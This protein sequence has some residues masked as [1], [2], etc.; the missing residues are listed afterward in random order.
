MKLIMENWRNYMQESSVIILDES[1]MQPNFLK[2]EQL[3]EGLLE[4]E[5]DPQA[6]GVD[7]LA[8][9]PVEKIQ[10]EYQKML[11]GET[12]KAI[13]KRTA[14]YRELD[15]ALQDAQGELS[16][17]E[18]PNDDYGGDI[19]VAFYNW[20]KSAISAIFNDKKKSK[21][22]EDEIQFANQNIEKIAKQMRHLL[23]T[24]Y[25]P[26]QRE[27]Y[28]AISLFTGANFPTIRNPEN[29]DSKQASVLKFVN[30]GVVDIFKP[31]KE[32][33]EKAKIILQKMVN[34]K[35]KPQ[36][37]WRGVGMTEKTG[38]Y[39]GLEEYKKGAVI[40]VGN[41]SSFST[42]ETVAK[43]FSAEE[44]DQW[45]VVLHIPSL[46]RGADVN[47]F[48]EYEDSENEIIVSGKFKILKMFYQYPASDKKVEINSFNSFKQ[49]VSSGT[50]QKPPEEG[51]TFKD[52]IIYVVLGESI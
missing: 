44:E 7:V 16:D 1:Q 12:E 9:I 29:F 43:G 33:Y 39:T 38:K 19:F 32:T 35:I 36:P 6:L 24:T 17:L 23:I 31:T 13:Q 40:D 30:D 49:N 27:I 28:R 21:S 3:T 2:Q 15:K 4:E 45:N 18:E 22:R 8:K 47:E 34:M 51:L 48:S 26:L 10:S 41:M 25:T 14:R 52:G 20:A 37:V 50:I 11:Q 5:K 42:E 46:S